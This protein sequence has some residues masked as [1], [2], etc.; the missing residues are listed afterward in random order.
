VEDIVNQSKQILKSSF[1]INDP[2]Q[3]NTY[4]IKHLLLV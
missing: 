3:Q 1:H 2:T 4:R